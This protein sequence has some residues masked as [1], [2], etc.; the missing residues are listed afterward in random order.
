V[1]G[2]LHFDVSFMAWILIGALGIFIAGDFHLSPAQKG[3]LVAVPTLSGAT[4]RVLVGAL[5]NRFGCRPVGFLTLACSLAGLALAAT[6][7]TSYPRMLAIGALLGVSGASFAVALPL[8]S[9]WFSGR[10]QGVALGIVGAGNSGSVIATFVAPRLAVAIG[11]HATL[12]LALVP[13]GIVTMVW[14]LVARDAP[15]APRTFTVPWRAPDL[16]A[17]MAVYSLTF[18]GFVG[19]SSFLPIYLHD[20]YGLAPI[21]AGTATT[22]IVLAGSA[23]RPVGGFVADQVGGRRVLLALFAVVVAAAGLEALL[24]AGAAIA[25]GSIVVLVALMAALGAGNGATFQVVPQRFGREI[26]AVT[27]IVGAAGGFGGFLLPNLL[28]SARTLG[29]T[30]GAGLA[31]FAA[32]ALAVAVGV[33][34]IHGRRWRPGGPAQQPAAAVLATADR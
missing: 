28:A 26:A 27:G 20:Q 7:G 33:I 21:A 18:G 29:G 9:H 10:R 6:A 4:V 32:V 3:L 16:Y 14:F 19:L 12:A 15:R 34:G 31:V 5:A 25:A 1:A 8:A 2:F 22:L 24:P 11:W 13:V 23:A 17:L 30:Y